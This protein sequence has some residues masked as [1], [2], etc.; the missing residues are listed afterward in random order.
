MAISIFSARQRPTRQILNMIMEMAMEGGV[1]VNNEEEAELREAYCYIDRRLARVSAPEPAVGVMKEAL[2][3]GHFPEY[4][5]RT[6]SYAVMERYNYQRGQWRDYTFS[7]TLP[8]YNEG[9]R[10][11]FSEVERPVERRE[12]Q[13]AYATYFTESHYH[14]G[15]DDYAKQI[16]FSHRILVNDDMG[17]FNSIIQ[18][19]GDS[20]RRFED[21]WVSALYDNIITTLTGLTGLGVNYAGTGMLTTA[22]LMIA[23]NAFLQRVD[24]MGYPL[25]IT[26]AYLVIP[27]VLQMTANQ[28]LQS[29]KIA[30]LATNGINPVRGA[31]QVRTDPYIA[32]TLPNVPWY[33]FADPGDIPAV[34]VVRLQGNPDGPELFAEAPSKIPMSPSGGLGTAD[35]RLGSFISGDIE[36]L[37][38]DTI[39]ARTDS[40]ASMV[41]VTDPNGI[42]WSSGTT[43]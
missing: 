42:Y 16:D 4:L 18:K 14:I 15:I 39:G 37:V 10:F 17:A 11:R 21:W 12:K 33:L 31:L 20:A 24:G 19:M 3:V 8:T 7:D 6:L 22:N 25:A 9:T 27:P 23:W 28:I 43:A 34:T 40:A 26:P 41:G 35:W 5:G 32:F 29:E 2:V 1:A 36:I 13:E 38:E 30:E